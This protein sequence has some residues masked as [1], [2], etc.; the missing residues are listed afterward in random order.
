[1]I[2]VSTKIPDFQL[3]SKT[4]LRE[5]N[6]SVKRIHKDVARDAKNILQEAILASDK[7]ATGGLFKSV[8]ARLLESTSNRFVTQI[9]FKSPGNEY[10]QYANFG[11]GSGGIPNLTSLRRWARAKGIEQKAVWAIARK[12]ADEGTE[13]VGEDAFMGDASIKI[14]RMF[15]RTVRKRIEELKRGYK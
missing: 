12:I 4:L 15:E 5:F 8:T 3:A 10:A 13:D 9:G 6:A 14:E 11:R 7:Y 1:M 2:K